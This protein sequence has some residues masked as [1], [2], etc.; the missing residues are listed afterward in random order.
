[1]D[2]V[3]Y[4]KL[5]NCRSA[6]ALP[7]LPLGID[8]APPETMSSTNLT[9]IPPL[10]NSDWRKGNPRSDASRYEDSCCYT[11]PER[12]ERSTPE[13]RREVLIKQ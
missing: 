4:I 13:A 2:N 8:A 6:L 3:I 5:S 10:S 7:C 12:L 1:M 11:G 9:L